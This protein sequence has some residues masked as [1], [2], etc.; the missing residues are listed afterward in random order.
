M[1]GTL[2]PDTSCYRDAS[3]RSGGILTKVRIAREILLNADK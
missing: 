3:L 1:G 2:L